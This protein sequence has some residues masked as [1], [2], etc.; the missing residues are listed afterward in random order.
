MRDYQIGGSLP[1]ESHSYVT[2]NADAEFYDA[3]SAGEFCYVLNSRQMGKSSLRVRVMQQLQSNGVV[4]GFSDL[5]GIGKVDSEDKWYAGIVKALVSSCKLTHKIQWRAWWQQQQDLTSPSQ[6]LREFIEE[7]LLVEIQSP[8][9]LFIDEIDRVLSQ[10][11]SLDN[12]FALIRYFYN[13]RVDHPVY[14]RLTFALLGVATPSDLIRDKTCTCFNI[15]RA[16]HLEGFHPHEVAPLTQGLLESVENPEAVMQEI[17]CWTGGQPFLTQK[18][19]Q[20]I[21]QTSLDYK[22]T[23]VEAVIRKRIIDDWESQ[24]EPQ[25]LRT[26][27]DRILRD[28]NRS[29]RLLSLFQQILQQGELEA[30]DRPEQWELQ[31]SG[32]VVKQQGRLRIYNPIYAEIFNSTWVQKQLD[33]LRPYATAFS[34]WIDSKGNDESRLLRGQ[35]LRESLDWSH[36]KNLSEQDYHFLN[37]SQSLEN[38]ELD[39]ILTAQQQ[40][41]FVLQQANK[42]LQKANL[43][44][45]QR[46]SLGVAVLTT[47][48]VLCHSSNDG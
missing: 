12:F 10:G 20:L 34:I 23:S 29:G 19:C 46:I 33:S 36:G 9:V 17:L 3:L 43:Q 39:S 1:F 21:V 22:F 7:V 28:E 42:I 26:I 18:I 15:G 35:A 37:A 27:R 44:A 40:V 4:C 5:T 41:N 31:L 32:L 25:H 16:I 11:F 24:D 13:R 30:G 47:T 45:K 2:R 38:R 6:R 14:K 8:I 48:L